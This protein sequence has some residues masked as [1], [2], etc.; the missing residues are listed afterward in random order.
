MFVLVDVTPLFATPVFKPKNAGR[1]VGRDVL[2]IFDDDR[3]CVVALWRENFLRIVAV[4]DCPVKQAALDAVI[5]GCV[6]GFQG[7][8]ECLV[9]ALPVQNCPEGNAEEVGE[10][11]I[12]GAQHAKLAGLLGE[13][14]LV[15]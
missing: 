3:L 7:L 8:H 13:F 10:L 4:T 6:A 9:L 15:G 5:R 2:A 1:C 12:G 11:Q 14:R